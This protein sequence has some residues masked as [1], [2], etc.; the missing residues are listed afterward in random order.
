MSLPDYHG[1]SIANL[2]TSIIAG[3][4]GE[5]DIYRPLTALDP[6]SLV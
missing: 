2:M 5:T 6:N 1:N 4:E 3:L